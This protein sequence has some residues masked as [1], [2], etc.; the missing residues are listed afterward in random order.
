MAVQGADE[1]HSIVNEQLICDDIE[2]RT[3]KLDDSGFD[4]KAAVLS[5]LLTKKN[6]LPTP[7]NGIKILQCKKRYVQ[8]NP[9]RHRKICAICSVHRG[10]AAG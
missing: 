3:V 1:A 6:V 2:W 4:G 5:E 8:P 10:Q 7:D 9:R